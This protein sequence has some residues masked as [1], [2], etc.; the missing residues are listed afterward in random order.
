LFKDERG[1]VKFDAVL[2]IP[3]NYRIP[4]LAKSDYSY[5]GK[6]ITGAL[7]MAFKSMRFKNGLDAEQIVDLAELIIET[8]GEDYLAFEDVMLFLQK[9]TRGEYEITGDSMTIIKF[10]KLFEIYRQRRW[11]EHQS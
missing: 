3:R 5:I 7:T 10:M 4:E 2:S 6:L 11:V 9:L 8:S 1:I